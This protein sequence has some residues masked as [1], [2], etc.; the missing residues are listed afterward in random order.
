MSYI[1][2]RIVTLC[3]I[4]LTS[5]SYVKIVVKLKY[6]NEEF[7]L[8]EDLPLVY[9]IEFQVR[10]S[11]NEILEKKVSSKLTLYKS[12]KDQNTFK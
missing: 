2:D 8:N 9:F 6:K 3:A 7:M 11:M 5:V 12:V 10:Y 1:F 4:I